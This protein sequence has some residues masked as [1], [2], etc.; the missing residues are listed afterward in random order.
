MSRLLACRWCSTKAHRGGPAAAAHAPGTHRVSTAT[1]RST[2]RRVLCTK[3]LGS[4]A[5]R[6]TRPPA[7]AAKLERDSRAGPPATARE[8][9][10]T[11]RP[12]TPVTTQWFQRICPPKPT[13]LQRRPWQSPPRGHGSGRASEPGPEG[14]EPT[15]PAGEGMRLPAPHPS[16]LPHHTRACT[17]R[18]DKSTRI[19]ASPAPT[20]SLRF[21]APVPQM[22]Q[23]VAPE[24]LRHGREAVPL[25]LRS[26]SRGP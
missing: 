21:P 11:A 12:G 19:L 23:A 13:D 14:R 18:G 24:A 10:R 7:C 16:A 3:C 4:P 22:P 1:M 17:P 15:E 26:P 5:G 25:R 9:P 20:A 6:R 8:T 2:D